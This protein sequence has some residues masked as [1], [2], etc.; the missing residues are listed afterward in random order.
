MVAFI[1]FRRHGIL[2]SNGYLDDS[3]RDIPELIMAVKKYYS[4]I[5][6]FSR[7]FRNY[8]KSIDGGVLKVFDFFV[9]YDRSIGYFGSPIMTCISYKEKGSCYMLEGFFVGRNSL[10]SIPFSMRNHFKEISYGVFSSS[11]ITTYGKNENLFR[12]IIEWLNEYSHSIAIIFQGEVFFLQPSVEIKGED[13]YFKL[14]YIEQL[15]KKLL[16]NYVMV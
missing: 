14:K 11:K 3:Q 15:S 8:K 1:S 9:Y 16:M 2:V 12:M 5:F 13:L 4:I 6:I 10:S 7:T